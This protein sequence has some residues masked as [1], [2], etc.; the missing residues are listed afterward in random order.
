MGRPRKPKTSDA[1]IQTDLPQNLIKLTME[2]LNDIIQQKMTTILEEKM[3]WID[4]KITSLSEQHT[5][6]N[7][8]FKI[9]DDDRYED[10]EILHGA[11][12]QVTTVI[13]EKIAEVQ[14]NISLQV[15]EVEARVEIVKQE[16]ARSKE[17]LHMELEKSTEMASKHDLKLDAVEQQLKSRNVVVHGIFEDDDETVKQKLVDLSNNVLGIHMKSL[18]I[19]NTFRYGKSTENRPRKLMVKF[20]SKKMRDDFYSNRKKTPITPSSS[21][22]IYI[23]EDLTQLRSK[24]FHDARNLVKIGKLHSTWTQYGNVMVKSTNND[25][26]TAIFCHRDLKDKYDVPN[27]G[28]EDYGDS[29]ATEDEM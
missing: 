22:N 28:L 8:R 18:D 10:K 29:N 26:P 17:Q 24:L 25:K 21:D 27:S 6:M 20:R 13:P 19:E 2:Q 14:N 5:E 23:N 3:K 1:E 7:R 12:Y 16:F 9:S 4:D 11:D 15:G